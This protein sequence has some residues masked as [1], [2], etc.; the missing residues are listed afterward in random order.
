MKE[1]LDRDEGARRLADDPQN[2]DALTLAGLAA[3][4]MNTIPLARTNFTALAAA[5]STSLLAENNLGVI[6]FQQKQNGEGLSHY[7]KAL[8]INSENRQVLDNIA[9]AMNTY[10]AAGGDKNGLSY[11]SLMKVFDPAETKM[12]QVMAKLGLQR[13]GSTWVTKERAN[14]SLAAHADVKDNLAKIDAQYKQAHDSLVALDNQ[15]RQCD[16]D[17]EMYLQRPSTPSTISSTCRG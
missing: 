14:R 2:P 3:Y 1:V 7:V 13:W 9:E 11:R 10:L 6:S 8:Q 5:D 15:V 4:R 16:S 12:E 17:Y